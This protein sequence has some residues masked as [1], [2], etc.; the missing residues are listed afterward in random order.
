MVHRMDP[1]PIPNWQPV[2]VG[3]RPMTATPGPMPAGGRRQWA[4]ELAWA[5][6]RV[7]VA[8]EGGRVRVTDARGTEIN[9]AYPELR[10]IGP[11]LGARVCLL[12]GEVVALGKDGRPDRTLLRRRPAGAGAPGARDAR[13][14]PVTL[15]AFDLLHLD[16]LDQT[17]LP[18]RDRRAR[19]EE[20]GLDG[21]RWSVAPAVPGTGRDAA[22]AARGLGLEGVV[23]KRLAS[24]Y[25][26]GTKSPDWVLVTK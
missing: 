23:A 11:A 26:P 16:G 1:P 15:L 20:L 18:Y 6:S 21:E 4:Y 3:L 12:D 22:E 2:P 9:A 24:R 10:G 17:G 7:M 5:G 19:L 8:V 13:E 14:V 25:Q